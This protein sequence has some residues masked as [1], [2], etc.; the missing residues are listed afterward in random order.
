MSLRPALAALL[1]VATPLAAQSATSTRSVS[2]TNHARR[3]F[4]HERHIR[5][6]FHAPSG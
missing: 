4:A 5:M 2:P 1:V 6:E 3:E